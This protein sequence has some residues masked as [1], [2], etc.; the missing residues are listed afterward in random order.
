VQGVVN[1][2]QLEGKSLYYFFSLFFPQN[3]VDL[4]VTETNRYALQ[5]FDTPAELPTHSRY[6]HDWED[7][8][9]ADMRIYLATQ[10]GMGLCSK[11]NI[12]D[13]WSDFW[14]T[15]VDGFKH[16]MTRNRFEIITSFLHFNDNI[17]HPERNDPAYDPLY[18]VCPLLDIV[19]PLYHQWYIPEREFSI[20]ES[21]VK[22][23]GRLFFKQYMPNKAIKWGIKIWAI[24]ESLSGYCL[25]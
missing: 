14:M 19:R 7:V 23:K 13:Y 16:Y 20:D 22:F 24:C 21:M 5:Y 11:P 18:K 10:I 15:A 3:A 8:T 1:L 9:D 4:M 6:H 17:E 2:G 12:E 25:D